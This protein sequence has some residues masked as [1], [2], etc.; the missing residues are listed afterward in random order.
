MQLA[1]RLE[2]SV[3]KSVHREEHRRKSQSRKM[4]LFPCTTALTTTTP[5]ALF[6]VKHLQFKEKLM[7][8]G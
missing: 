7:S 8:S 5:P 3:T 4:S 1:G 2:P 6:L